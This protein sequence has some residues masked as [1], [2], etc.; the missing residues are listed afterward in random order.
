MSSCASSR[1]TPDAR[2][3]TCRCRRCVA[4]AGGDAESPLFET[5]NAMTSTEIAFELTQA[6]GSMRLCIATYEVLD[7]DGTLLWSCITSLKTVGTL[8]APGQQGLLCKAKAKAKPD[9]HRRAERI[10]ESMLAGDPFAEDAP[11]AKTAAPLTSKPSAARGGRSGVA[12]AERGGNIGEPMSAHLRKGKDN[13]ESR[14]SAG[15]PNEGEA[16]TPVPG[17]PPNPPTL[18]QPTGEA[19]VE[20]M[21]MASLEHELAAIW[22]DDFERGLDD[23]EDE[24][25]DQ[26]PS[27]GVA[28]VGDG[29]GFDAQ[30]AMSAPDDAIAAEIAAAPLGSAALLGGADARTTLPK[31]LSN[32][33]RPSPPQAVP[34]AI[35]GTFAQHLRLSAGMYMP[36]VALS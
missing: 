33:R 30:G 1:R 36:E 12:H 16:T 32:R 4:F 20:D 35:L 34:P 14:T 18:C 10:F 29:S 25:E 6:L 26:E 31:V 8:W 7:K 17:L 9:D 13:D 21:D 19:E 28:F 5:I 3:R 2:N 27:L 22:A 23:L 11:V 15:L 24:E